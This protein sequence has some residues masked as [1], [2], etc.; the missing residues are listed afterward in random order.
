M[1]KYFL[2]DTMATMDTLTGIVNQALDCIGKG[3]M[4]QDINRRVVFFNHAC[5]EIT[6]WSRAEVIGKDCGDI[7]LCHTSTGMCLTEK[8]CPGMEIFHGGLSQGSRELL[9]RRGDG[10]ESWVKMSVSPLK[11][12]GGKVTHLVSVIE[13]ISD[14]KRF[15]DEVLRSKTLSTLGAF[16]AELAHEVK[17]PLN[18]M[19]IQ[20]TVLERE[21]HDIKKLG[22]RAKKELLDVVTIVQKE[23]HRLSGFVEECLHFSKTGEL[24]KSSVH[25]GDL[26]SEIVSLLLPQAQ[27]QG[28]QIEFVIKNALPEIMIDRDKI[29][30]A[31]LNILI[32]GI[33]A[34]PDGGILQVSA[35]R[36]E[37]EIG[38]SCQDTGPGIPDEIRDKIFHLF[39]T[40]KDGG[41]G[42]GLSF[43]Q[44]IVQ[45]HGGIIRLEASSR[46]SKFVIA[47]PIS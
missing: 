37:Q 3:I 4:I 23:L 40:T 8:F 43:A 18:A 2:L 21:I 22:D 30:Q 36:I 45:A 28:I 42:I 35:K 19:N 5:E 38:I 16:A 7:F 26:L 33:E 14:I 27:L 13:D 46:G 31:I 1:S 11:T 32:N 15:S 44:N 39:Y 24:N 6:K 9:I 41:T 20:M 47:L 34:M 25:V 29:K 17:N 12:P 10:T